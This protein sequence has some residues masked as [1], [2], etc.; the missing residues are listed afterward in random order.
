MDNNRIKRDCRVKQPYTRCGDGDRLFKALG[1][2]E[3]LF[4]ID[5]PTEI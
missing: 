4:D 5:A 1:A 3:P 2:F